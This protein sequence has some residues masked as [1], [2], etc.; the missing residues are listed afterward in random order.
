MESNAVPLTGLRP[1]VTKVLVVRGASYDPRN[2][3]NNEVLATVTD[4]EAI[5]DL[6]EALRAMLSDT[7]L[8]T[9]GDPTIVL[10]EDRR[11]LAA[12]TCKSFR[13]VCCPGQWDLDAHVTDPRRL[14]AWLTRHV[15][16]AL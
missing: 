5:A 3:K 6:F 16:D 4:M 12:I 7:A 15:G 2:R 9:P 8:M 10:L 11:V 1:S 14:R 13:Y